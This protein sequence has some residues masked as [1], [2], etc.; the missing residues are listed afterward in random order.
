VIARC[1][2]NALFGALFLLATAA[3][4]RDDVWAWEPATGPVY[5]YLVYMW[6]PFRG[7]EVVIAIGGAPAGVSTF[8][9]R[10]AHLW[11]PYSLTVE[12]LGLNGQRRASDMSVM[13]GE[14]RPPP[15]PADP[16][17]VPEPNATLMLVVGVAFLAV[18]GRKR[19]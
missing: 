17:P 3:S 14:P 8:T 2:R 13:R 10:D 5:Y 9:F 19:R 6:L 4:A 1:A 12:A 18:V 16:T 7:E 15:E 11:E